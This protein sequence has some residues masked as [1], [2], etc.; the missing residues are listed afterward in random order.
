MDVIYACNKVLFNMISIWFD[1]MLLYSTWNCVQSEYHSPLDYDEILVTRSDPNE[2]ICDACKYYVSAM[3]IVN[4]DESLSSGSIP[5]SRGCEVPADCCR[6]QMYQA[7][8]TGIYSD[9]VMERCDKV[10]SWSK[11]NT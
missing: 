9:Q 3:S 8:A 6:F 10:T 4:P 2:E 1:N 7:A 11:Q 5:D